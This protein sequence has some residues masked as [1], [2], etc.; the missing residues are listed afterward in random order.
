MTDASTPRTIRTPDERFAA[1]PDLPFEP[2]YV[3]VDGVRLARVDEGHGHPVVL[4]HGV[5]TWSY[6]WRAVVPSLLDAGLRAIAVDQLGFGRSDK[7][8]DR[9]WFTYDRLVASF[10]AHLD[11]LALDEPITLV[12]HDWGGPVGLRWAMEHPDRV[13]R[14]V[15]L[16]TGVFTGGH[17]ALSE[18]WQAFRS[19]VAAADELPIG[20]LVQL[21]TSRELTDGEVAAYD[22]PFPDGAFQAGPLALP[23]LIPLEDDDPGAA[24]MIATAR[25]L[26]TFDRSTL[27]L[28]GAHDR[29]LRRADGERLAEAIPGAGDLE[30]LEGAHFV[31][32]DAGPAIGRRIA[33]FVL[34]T[35]SAG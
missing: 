19:M 21:G 30:V 18:T 13:A 9:S 7:P 28:W 6:L 16:D 11:A 1:L 3:E 27:V 32:E 26:R 31:Q 22:A 5:P 15:L 14:L 12:V 10:T 17:R 20:Q 33:R 2:R 8:V 29:V 35:P 34:E 4:V 23:L 24:E 25:A